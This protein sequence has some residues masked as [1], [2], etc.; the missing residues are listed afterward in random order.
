[1]PNKTFRVGDYA[2]GPFSG[3]PLFLPGIIIKSGNIMPENEDFYPQV[4][5]RYVSEL[6]SAR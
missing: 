1:M 2:D 4:M 5:Q 6:I 3:I